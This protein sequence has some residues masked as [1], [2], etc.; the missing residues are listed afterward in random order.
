MNRERAGA[1]ADA[2]LE[3]RIR[4]YELAAEMQTS[5][6]ELAVNVI[7][8]AR[9]QGAIAFGSII[10]SNMANIGLIVGCTAILRPI[11]VKGVVI[12]RELPMML[13]ATAGAL[14]MGFDSTLSAGGSLRPFPAR[15][16]FWGPIPRAMHGWSAS[17]IPTPVR[18]TRPLS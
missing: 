15:N 2:E 5:A 13:L 9:D 12:R 10:G 7:A 4:S 6:P 11:V 18:S 17:S 3:A 8:A 1:G 16:S 14:A